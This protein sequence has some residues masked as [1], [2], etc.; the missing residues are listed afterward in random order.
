MSHTIDTTNL[1]FIRTERKQLGL[2]FFKR[3]CAFYQNQRE[4]ALSPIWEGIHKQYYDQ[5]MRAAKEGN[6]GALQTYFDYLFDNWTLYG[7]DVGVVSG[8]EKAQGIARWC[9]YLLGVGT[10]IGAVCEYNPEQGN[11][12]VYDPEAILL[13]LSLHGLSMNHPGAPGMPGISIN[14]TKFIPSK[15]LDAA[16]SWLAIQEASPHPRVV[17]ELGSGEAFLGYAAIKNGTL[18]YHSVDL[19][20]TS[21][22]GAY[23]NAHAFGEEAV[24]LSGEPNNGSAKQFFH[25]LSLSENDFPYDAAFNQDSLPE[26]TESEATANLNYIKDNLSHGGVFVSLNHESRLYGQGRVSEW[27]AKVGGF[28]PVSRRKSWNRTGYLEEVWRV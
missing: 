20:M 28:T 11:A 10:R 14:G 18:Q 5:F 23:L 16:N 17:L 19:P 21:M 12:A 13:A 22:F 25:G 4:P 15:L 24:W 9:K 1:Q 3:L 6:A 8:F 7:L 27:I 26:M 2:D